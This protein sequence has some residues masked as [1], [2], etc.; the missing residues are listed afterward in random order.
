MDEGTQDFSSTSAR[1]NRALQDNVDRNEP[2]IV[3]SYG[4]IGAILL[5]GAV[6]FA[7]DRWADTSPWALV[8]GLA[9]GILL[10]FFQLLRTVRHP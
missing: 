4:L 6:G 8:F 7:I 3:A 9:A 1:A 2:R 5:L 10:G